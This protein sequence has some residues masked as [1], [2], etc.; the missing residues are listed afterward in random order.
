M[1]TGDGKHLVGIFPKDSNSMVSKQLT[2]EEKPSNR[3]IIRD[4]KKSIGRV[5]IGSDNGWARWARDG[6][7]RT[8]KTPNV[9]LNYSS[10]SIY[11]PTIQSVP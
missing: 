3:Q 4:F 8:K 1:L 2:Y 7:R 9:S 10:T 11:R 5:Y 6:E